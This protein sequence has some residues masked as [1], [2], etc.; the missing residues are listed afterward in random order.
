MTADAS[1]TFHVIKDDGSHWNL[2]YTAQG[3]RWTPIAPLAQT[4][5][6][7]APYIGPGPAQTIMAVAD[8]AAHLMGAWEARQ[9]RLRDEAAHEEARRTL[10]LMDMIGRWGAV[11][12]GADSVDLVVSD[13]LAREAK[14]M[15]DIIIANKRVALPQSMLYELASIQDVLHS[16]SHLVAGQFDVLAQ[17]PDID[18]AGSIDAV[19]PDRKLDLEFVATLATDPAVEWAQHVTNKSTA[20]FDKTMAAVLRNPTI[21]QQ[22][23]FPST[24]IALVEPT[25]NEPVGLMQKLVRVVAPALPR[26]NLPEYKSDAADKR[27]L[28][29]ELALL[30]SEVARA[31]ALTAAWLATSEIVTTAHGRE[32][33]VSATTGGLAMTLGRRATQRAIEG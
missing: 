12:A 25:E 5:T 19:M 3:T 33:Q 4:S 10:W 6:S 32:L 9:H 26:L 15:M 20:D 17:A 11:H 28:Y 30:P 24:S 1:R 31:K 18:L 29:R 16:Y 13:Y 22:R 23:L 14:A 7:A 8:T 21:F 2:Q 27:D